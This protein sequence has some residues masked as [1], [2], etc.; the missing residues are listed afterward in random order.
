MKKNQER[1]ESPPPKPQR[2][3]GHAKRVPPLNPEDEKVNDHVNHLKEQMEQRVLRLLA[4][5]EDGDSDPGAGRASDTGYGKSLR[6]QASNCEPN[7]G[8]K[9]CQYRSATMDVDQELYRD[10]KVSYGI[11]RPEESN[12]NLSPEAKARREQIYKYKQTGKDL[13]G[14]AQDHVKQYALTMDRN[15]TQKRARQNHDGRFA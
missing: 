2:F 11:D 12:L 6:K 10:F 7:R 4:N 15:A 3:A 13:P 14:F 9:A 1:Y 5:G 8:T